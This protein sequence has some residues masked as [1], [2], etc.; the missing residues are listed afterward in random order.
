MMTICSLSGCKKSV[1]LVF[2]IIA[3]RGNRQIPN[4]QQKLC[5]TRQN[6]LS[7]RKMMKNFDRGKLSK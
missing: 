3:G 5:Q 4:L 1:F 2:S 7:S 6:F